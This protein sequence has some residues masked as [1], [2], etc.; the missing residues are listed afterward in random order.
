ML[1]EEIQ[2][3]IDL[4]TLEEVSSEELEEILAK[5]HLFFISL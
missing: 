3:K 4:G 5:A 2:K 1:K